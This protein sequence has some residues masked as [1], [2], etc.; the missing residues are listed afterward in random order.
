MMDRV[1][2]S[3]FEHRFTCM[4]AGGFQKDKKHSQRA[5]SCYDSSALAAFQAPM[6]KKKFPCPKMQPHADATGSQEVSSSPACSAGAEQPEDPAPPAFECAAAYRARVSQMAR[7]DLV[8][9]CHRRSIK[10]S[11]STKELATRLSALPPPSPKAAP[12]SERSCVLQDVSGHY[13]V[14]NTR[15]PDNAAAVVTTK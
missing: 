8:A 4:T 14:A 7:A 9:E 5:S 2:L 12:N 15:S 1:Q 6:T 3:S 10:G 13:L 11:G